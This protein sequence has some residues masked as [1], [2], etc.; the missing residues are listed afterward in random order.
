MTRPQVRTWY[1]VRQQT[2]Y[3]H[4]KD[5]ADILSATQTVPQ[6]RIDCFQFIQSSKE[7]NI[8]GW[9]GTVMS[10]ID[11]SEGIRVVL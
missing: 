3:R 4:L 5:P 11:T 10:A 9:T 6:A 7:Y 8:V 1:A 2:E